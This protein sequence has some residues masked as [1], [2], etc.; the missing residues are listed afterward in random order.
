MRYKRKLQRG[1]VTLSLGFEDNKLG[2]P[3]TD[4]V[5]S[6]C[7]GR[8]PKLVQKSTTKSGNP[9]SYRRLSCLSAVLDGVVDVPPDLLEVRL[10]VQRAH[11]DVLLLRVANLDRFGLVH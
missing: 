1:V 4:A 2:N 8:A 11:E 3:L 6:H 9:G 5:A 7:T 10:A